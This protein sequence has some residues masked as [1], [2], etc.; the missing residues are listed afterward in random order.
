[1]K[2][3]DILLPLSLAFLTTFGLH[4]FFTPSGSSKTDQIRSGQT[5]QALSSQEMLK[6]LN[7]EIVFSDTELPESPQEVTLQTPHTTAQLSAAG[8]SIQ[9]LTFKRLINH[10]EEMLKTLTQEPLVEREKQPFIIGLD[11]VTPYLYTLG[12]TQDTETT[13]KVTFY[14]DNAAAYITKEFSFSPDSYKLHITL[15]IEPKDPKTGVQARLFV[16]GPAFTPEGHTPEPRAL[17]YTDADALKKL[18]IRDIAPNTVWAAPAIFGAEDRYFIHALIA[19]PQHFTQRAFYKITGATTLTAILEGP[20]IHQ[21]TTWNLSFY[22]GPKELDSLIAA[23]PR[24]EDTLEYGWF[25]PISKML[26]YILKFFYRF[27]PNYGFA[28]ILLTLLI[29][30]ALMPLTIKGA[31]SMQKQAD[32]L[33]KR[34]YIEQKY[35]HD[36]ERLALERQELYAKQVSGGEFSGCLPLLIQTPFFIGLNRLLSNSIELYHAPFLW[37]SDLSVSDPYYILPTLMA[38]GI[39]WRTGSQ[40]SDPRQ[41]VATLFLALFGAGVI[42][43]FLSA[44]LTLFLLVNIFAGVLQYYI[45][46]ALKL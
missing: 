36:P 7:D 43:N 1:M 11:T 16:P 19:D 14:A 21:K 5:F 37:I 39:I 25:A 18:K 9:S 29:N 26:L 24:L 46:K 32:L 40:S 44:G 10:H 38:V 45:Q 6:P 12:E 13:K 34:Q 8:A 33:K 20:V 35:R 27:L 4:Y 2:F 15:T 31:A 42:A 23:D 17:V 22:C 28:I 3:Q 41:H 30:L